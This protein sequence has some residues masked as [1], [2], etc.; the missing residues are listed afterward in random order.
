MYIFGEGYDLLD[1]SDTEGNMPPWHDAEWRS[2]IKNAIVE[3]GMNCIGSYYFFDLDRLEFAYLAD[4]VDLIGDRLFYKDN[5][6]SQ[7]KLPATV[8]NFGKAVF[9]SCTWLEEIVVPQLL[10]LPNDTFENCTSLKKVT[11]PDGLG[12]IGKNSFTGCYSLG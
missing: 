4:S 9:A 6:L 3:D 12:I 10:I 8:A 2:I 1:Y 5:L 7:V 11:L